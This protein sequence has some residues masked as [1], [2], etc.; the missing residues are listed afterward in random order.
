MQRDE[1]IDLQ[2][3]N[4]SYNPEIVIIWLSSNIVQYNTILSKKRFKSTLKS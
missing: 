4:L 1:D 3:N 2:P